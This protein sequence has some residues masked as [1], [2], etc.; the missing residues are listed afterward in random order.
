MI[1]AISLAKTIAGLKEQ[2]LEVMNNVVA[3]LVVAPDTPP[4]PP[5][6][7]ATAAEGDA[8]AEAMLEPVPEGV[9]IDPT[10]MI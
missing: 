5:T 9:V 8:A 1:Q 10:K 6:D 2:W 4:Q 3:P 7:V